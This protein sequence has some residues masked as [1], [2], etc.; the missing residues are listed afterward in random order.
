MRERERKGGGESRRKSIIDDDN[1]AD[2]VDVIRIM[3]GTECT[4]EQK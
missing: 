1:D 2:N 3:I 4:N